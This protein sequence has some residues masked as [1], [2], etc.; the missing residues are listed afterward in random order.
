MFF[1]TTGMIIFSYGVTLEIVPNI[2]DDFFISASLWLALLWSAQF[3][4]GHFNFAVTVS[5]LSKRSKVID[6]ISYLISQVIGSFIGGAL[7]I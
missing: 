6:V 3:T 5:Q 1:E 7:C 2:P 4:G